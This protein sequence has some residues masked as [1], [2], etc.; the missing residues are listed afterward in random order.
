MIDDPEFPPVG[1][2]PTTQAWPAGASGRRRPRRSSWSSAT[3]P[4]PDH[5]DGRPSRAATSASRP[6]ARAG[7]AVPLQARR[8]EPQ[9]RPDSRCQPDGVDG[10]SAVCD[11]GQFS[12]DEGDWQGID[13]DRLV[14]YELHVGTFTPE[15]TF[16]A[17]HPRIDELLDLGITAIEIMPVAQFPGE[18]S[19]GY[20]GV[21]PFAVQ[22]SYGGPE[23][24]QTAGGSV[25]PPGDGGPPGRD[26]QPLRPRGEH[27]QRLR[28]VPDRQVQVRL[29]AA[30][31]FDDK[32]CDAVRAF[33]LDNVR[34]WV[35]DYRFDGLRLDAADQ[36]Y[37]RGPTHIIRQI[38]E[39]AP[40]GRRSSAAR[41]T[42]SPRPTSTTPRG[43]SGPPS[44]AATPSTATGPTTSTTP[45]TP[46]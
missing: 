38:G 4:R 42:S 39:V 35:G 43:S 27:P 17:V 15:G 22:N 37:D 28:P 44:R 19:W 6:P 14:I 2:I 45:R 31:N 25:P 24:L 21:F 13:R 11:P 9:G 30:L 34:M 18:R 41:S 7:A 46:P 40:R 8:R 5:P 16:D 29:G 3:G 23:G 32:Q 1:V 20:D 12:W 33:V 36:I 26:L 10:P